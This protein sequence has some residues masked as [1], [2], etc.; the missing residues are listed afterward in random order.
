MGLATLATSEVPAIQTAIAFASNSFANIDMVFVCLSQCLSQIQNNIGAMRNR[1]TKMQ[2]N[3][4]EL[5]CVIP[6]ARLG[7]KVAE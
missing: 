6:N 1:S 5:V 4:I 2:R 7:M 3:K